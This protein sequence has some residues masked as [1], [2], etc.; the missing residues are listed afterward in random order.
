[1]F[2]ISKNSLHKLVTAK[3]SNLHKTSYSCWEQYLCSRL[4]WGNCWMR[5]V[6]S[7]LRQWSCRRFV[8]FVIWCSWS[9]WT[10]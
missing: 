3:S 5:K 1:V 4:H 9:W 2:K 10:A 7:R 6:G 8:D